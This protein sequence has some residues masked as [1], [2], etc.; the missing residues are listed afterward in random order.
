[1]SHSEFNRVVMFRVTH[2][3]FFRYFYL[4]KLSYLYSVVIGFFI[5]Y[6]V[7]YLVSQILHALKVGGTDE[8]Y[9]NGNRN[10]LNY[11]LFFPPIAKRMKR[12]HATKRDRL[13]S[14]SNNLLNVS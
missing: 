2:L 5:T 7:G 3:L 4:Y 12:Q 13:L 8:V 1:M 6:T 10:L 14:N 11:D 9:I